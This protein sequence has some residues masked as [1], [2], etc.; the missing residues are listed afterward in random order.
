MWG[1]RTH[2][3]GSWRRGRTW[4]NRH[5]GVEEGAEEFEYMWRRD[6]KYQLDLRHTGEAAA[7]RAAT[8]DTTTTTTREEARTKMV[9]RV[10][11]SVRA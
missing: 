3:I 11:R 5:L 4:A 9:E 1:S 10:A 8:A 6:D 7:L 2:T